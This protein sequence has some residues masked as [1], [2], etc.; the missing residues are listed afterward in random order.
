MTKLDRK[1]VLDNFYQVL[2]RTDR[3]TKD[4][5]LGLCLAETFSTSPLQ[6]IN[7]I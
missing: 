4:G 7:R 3:K 6:P 2:F 5:R 1:K